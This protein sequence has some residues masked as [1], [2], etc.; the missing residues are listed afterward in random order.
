[1]RLTELAHQ[2]LAALIQAGDKVVDASAGNGNDT[3]FLAEKVTASGKV[4]AI[5]IQA[6]AITATSALLRSKNIDW[7]ELLHADHADLANLIPPFCRL[8]AAVFNLGYL[9]KADKSVTTRA[10]STLTA[11]NACLKF[12]AHPAM[13]SILAYRAHP[14]GEDEYRE[15]TAWLESLDSEKFA[16]QSYS[17]PNTRNPAPVLVTIHTLD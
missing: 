12:L 5:D 15:I 6:Q 16:I 7:V 3:L 14:G 10:S 2:K 1:M 11:L 17:V 4:Y 8:R 13:I 9:P